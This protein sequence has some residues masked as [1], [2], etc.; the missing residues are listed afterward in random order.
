MSKGREKNRCSYLL[1]LSLTSQRRFSGTTGRRD[2]K[3]Q[4]NSAFVVAL[5]RGNHGI[6]TTTNIKFDQGCLS[7]TKLFF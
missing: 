5:I 4:Y 2:G 1:S 6:K 3:R 7:P